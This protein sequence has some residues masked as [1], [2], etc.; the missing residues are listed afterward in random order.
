MTYCDFFDFYFKA[1]KK[2]IKNNQIYYKI[3][4]ASLLTNINHTSKVIKT[5]KATLEEIIIKS[6]GNPQTSK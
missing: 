3:D 5:T 2:S 4:L 1:A 6:H